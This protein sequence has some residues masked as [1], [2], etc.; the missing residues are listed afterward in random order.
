MLIRGGRALDPKTLCLVESDIWIEGDTIARV[1][2]S[3]PAPPGAHVFEAKGRI[4]LPGLVNCHTH[5]HNNL[6]KGM[7]DNWT[8]EDSRNFARALFANRTPE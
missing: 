2:A 8:L 6:L 3:L 1:G 7:S 5:A 4:L